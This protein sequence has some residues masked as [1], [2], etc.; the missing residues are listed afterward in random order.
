MDA[1]TEKTGLHLQQALL[2]ETQWVTRRVAVLFQGKNEMF[3]TTSEF[4][5]MRNLVR[6]QFGSSYFCMVHLIM[7]K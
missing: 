6:K 5:D 1:A 7:E 3:T 4:K 2:A